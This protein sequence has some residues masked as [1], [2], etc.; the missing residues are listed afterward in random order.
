[1]RPLEP[2]G[3]GRELFKDGL[4]FHTKRDLQLRRCQ[5]TCVF[6]ICDQLSCQLERRM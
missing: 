5:I 3:L 1:M 4:Y 2:F 6:P